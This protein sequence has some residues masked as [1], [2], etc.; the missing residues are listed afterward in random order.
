MDVVV[1]RTEDR[2]SRGQRRIVCQVP[3]FKKG[4]SADENS[5]I[6]M[7]RSLIVENNYGYVL[8]NLG[9][10]DGIVALRDQIRS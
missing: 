4:A 8:Q 2:L 3:V 10:I 5:L 1:Y 9:G 7:G 6:S